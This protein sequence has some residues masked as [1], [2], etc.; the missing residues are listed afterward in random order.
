[1]ALCPSNFGVIELAETAAKIAL[2]NW[3]GKITDI[4]L[5]VV[6]T[7][8][9]LDMSRPLSSWIMERLKLKGPI[10]SYE[11]K[12]ACFAGTLAIRQAVEW[13]LSGNDRGRAALVIAADQGLYAFSHPGEPTQGSG[14]AAFIIDKPEIAI[15]EPI[16]YAWSS[17]EYDFWRPIGEAFPNVNGR[18]SMECYKLAVAECFK[19]LMQ[20]SNNL[21]NILHNYAYCCFHVPFPK[22][23]MKA[24]TY[25]GNVYGLTQEQISTIYK[26][27]IHPTLEWNMK[28]G[29]CYTASLWFSTAKALTN[30]LKNEQL[31]SFSY[32]SG[33]GA[34]LLTITANNN[35]Q[36]PYW[37]K[38]LQSDFDNRQFITSEEYSSLRNVKKLPTTTNSKELVS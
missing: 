22:M 33:F 37:Q 35:K 18:L 13:K 20:G 4:G 2:E 9:G 16:S 32:G 3:S 38:H 27:K 19:Q 28:I 26:Q 14:A 25:L 36:N 8:S 12:H 1:M 30:M 11:V 21:E 34:E 6:G 5:I 7:E 29:N 24:F 15:I 23:V 17:P 31:L 10:R